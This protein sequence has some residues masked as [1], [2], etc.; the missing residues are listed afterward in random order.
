MAF[1]STA[2]IALLLARV[3]FGGVIAFMGLNHFL[4]TEG[5]AGYADAK[6]V[7]FPTASVLVSGA[8]LVLGGLGIFLGV[9]PALAAGLVVGFFL[10]VTPVMHDF[11]AA[12]E[13]QQQAEMTQ[14]LKNAALLGA[15]LAFV[16][17]A[18]QAWPYSLG[19][20]LV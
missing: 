7:P 10:V 12:S 6:G 16:A 13:D 18:T 9:Y 5:M 20:G 1:E 8:A 11:W 14:F 2:G 4:D 3:G 15:G 19:L 17:L